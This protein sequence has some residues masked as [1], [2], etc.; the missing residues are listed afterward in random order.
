MRQ[1]NFT[2]SQV[3]ACFY[4]TLRINKG[5]SREWSKVK[6]GNAL[7]DTERTKLNFEVRPH[8]SALNPADFFKHNRGQG[9]AA[10]HKEVT[11]RTARMHGDEKQLS[12]AVGVIITMP[13]DYIKRE[14][15]LT[16]EEFMAIEHYVESEGKNKP[17][18]QA[19]D[20]AMKKLS[21]INYDEQDLEM[22]R[23][24]FEAA[25]RAWMKN[26]GIREED[27]LYSVVHLDESWPHLHIMALPTVIERSIDRLTGD[28]VIKIKYTTSKFNNHTTHYYDT[29]HENV[30]N[31]MREEG[32]DASGLLN[33]ATKDR[34]FTPGDL[35]RQQRKDG[36]EMA[37]LTRAISKQK[38]ILIEQVAETE[39]VLNAH[40]QLLSDFNSAVESRVD[41]ILP[42][43]I[44]EYKEKEEQI[45][46]EKEAQEKKRVE[47]EE[48]AKN[49][50]K[51]KQEVEHM[52]R[53]MDKIINDRVKKR[54]VSIIRDKIVEIFSML[55]VRVHTIL[56]GS[57]Q[58]HLLDKISSI[59][60]PDKLVVDGK[61]YGGMSI[62]DALEKAEQRDIRD[63]LHDKGVPYTD[64]DAT[65]IV[66]VKKVIKRGKTLNEALTLVANEISNDGPRGH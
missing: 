6:E 27:M 51:Q 52:Q 62:G 43:E 23:E 48:Q 17:K 60:L 53:D 35:S 57:H 49:L 21:H 4:E 37:Q 66:R 8:H 25:L 45:R 19:F 29:L 64:I 33:G 47:L 46:K 20:T 30:I 50:E 42:E 63:M 1:E 14:V 26:A 16:D 9:I 65:D 56:K 18:S 44:K 7:I 32:I 15:D 28:P 24:F 41:E 5:S 34:A 11:G 59:K 61:E 36:V 12:K 31:L 38:D 55:S 13:R 10:Y 22:I 58:E 39:S 54:L 3:D 2:Y 40:T